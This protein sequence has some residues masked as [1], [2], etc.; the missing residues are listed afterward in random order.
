MKITKI[1]TMHVEPRWLFIKMYTNKDIVG[2]GEPIVEG[3]ARSVESEIKNIEEYLIGKDPRQIEHHWQTIYRGGFYRGGPI[4]T[5]A[6]SGIEQAMWDITAKELNVPIYRLLG[7]KVRDKVKMYTHLGGATKEELLKNAQSI[8]DN[9]FTTMKMAFDAPIAFH[10][11]KEVIDNFVDMFKSL[12]ETLGNNI[13]IAIDFHGRFSPAL[14]KRIISQLEPYY[15]MFIEEPCLPENVDMMQDI[16]MSTTIPIASGERIFT[17]WGFRELLIK[18]AVS[19]VQPDLC[20]AGGIFE[21]KK[22]AAMAECN[23]AM[24]APH[25]PLGPISLSA[26]LQLDM[27]TPN[28]LI[29]EFV[30]TGEGYLKEP[31][32]V[33]NGFIE[34]SEKPGLGI[35]LDENFI[36]EKIYE[37]NWKTPIV[38]DKNDNSISDW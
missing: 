5:S 22:I 8:V 11:P 18:N 30:N 26:A 20:H 36:K 28:F 32:E 1:E 3:H 37:G 35:E 15:P 12:R 16:A 4:L 23:Y 19:I 33:N 21:C 38:N 14:S 13:D 7:G 2:Y 6:L 10:E 27:C 34:V 25:N 29:Q 24:I 31:F 9:G 17:K